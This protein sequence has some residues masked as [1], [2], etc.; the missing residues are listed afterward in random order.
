MAKVKQI[1]IGRYCWM[2]LGIWT[3]FVGVTLIWSLFDHHTEAIEVVKSR[4]DNAFNRD[5]LYR[6]W[7]S[8]HGGVYVPVT[9]DTPP[10][11][12][13]DHLSDRDLKT[14]EGQKLTLMNPAYMT[15][16]VHDLGRELYGY[17]GHITSLDPIRPENVGDPW[18]I[19][20]MKAF[21]QGAKEIAAIETIGGEP[22]YRFMRPV[23]TKESCLRCHGQQGYQVGDIRGG[24]SVSVPMGPQLAI[25]RSGT[26]TLLFRYTCL[27]IVGITSILYLSRVLARQIRMRYDVE[28]SLRKSQELFRSV[29]RI[30]SIGACEWHLEEDYVECSEEVYR[31]FEY[32]LETR[33][34]SEEILAR[35]HPEDVPGYLAMQQEWITH[36]MGPDPAFRIIR[37]DGEIRHIKIDCVA[38]YNAA[39]QVTSFCGMVIDVTELE[40]V[41][42]EL[43]VQ[44][45]FIMTVLDN[46]P[47]G[48]AVHSVEEPMPFSYM[49]E[50][51]RRLYGFYPERPETVDDFWRMTY[52][53]E[54]YREQIKAQ[55]LADLASSDTGRMAWDNVPIKEEDGNLRYISAMN[56]PIEE[57]KM[58]IGVV[59]DVDTQHRALQEAMEMRSIA[60]AAS[61]AKGAFLANMSHEIRTPLNAVLGFAQLLTEKVSKEERQEYAR[62]IQAS[63]TALLDLIN[64]I[65][66]ISKLESSNTD[67]QIKPV[68]IQTI[69]DDLQRLF[70]LS[71]KE[72]GLFINATSAGNIP[73]LMLD[74]TKLRQ[75]L[76][77]LI[78]NAIK[79][80]EQ[81]VVTIRA[82][83]DMFG[84]SCDLMVEVAD[85]GEGIP[86]DQLERIFN[87]FQQREGQD[88]SRYG[89][90][91]L[92]LAI[93]KR[94]TELL[95]GTLEVESIVGEGSAFTIHLTDVPIA[96]DEQ[97]TV[98]DP[99]ELPTSFEGSH[100]LVVDDIASNRIVLTAMLRSVGA[101]VEEADNGRD[102]L[103]RIGDCIP[104]LVLTDY[105]MPVMDGLELARQLN[106]SPCTR[107]LPIIAVTATNELAALESLDLFD[108]IIPKPIR[109]E[110]LIKILAKYVTVG[111]R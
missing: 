67:M 104:D 66:E 103:D 44:N 59:W 85:T 16:Q 101:Q 38:R 89:G 81:G 58:T 74:G 8:M 37:S 22:Y 1:Q 55:V 46:L 36:G 10:N 53:D 13:L 96:T 98:E 88:P 20:A 25:S 68:N 62:A 24:I 108:E 77:N 34:T 30:A 56:I 41:K 83:V 18:E 92:G 110:H 91:G 28:R 6:T 76:I 94:V 106:E 70:G 14:P 3:I 29:E 43:A 17:Q 93:S 11:P 90:T 57:R 23:F 31:I 26:I 73:S 105:R 19:E 4:A 60:E 86:P 39:G 40:Q 2:L 80:T 84:D 79:F 35:I 7:A 75:V 33:L 99:T 71:A 47:I 9:E 12:H 21:E 64:D 97:V 82:E 51:F 107:T 15:R 69:F 50:K 61:E 42:R 48:V 87:V 49:N 111:T 63:G 100:V 52:R 27:W 65:L 109:R 78:G 102:A 95:G 5:L 54:E 45:Q 72:K 32:P